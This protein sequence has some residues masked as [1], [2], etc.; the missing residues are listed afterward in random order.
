[1]RPRYGVIHAAS[2]SKRDEL[3]QALRTA[4]FTAA[5]LHLDALQL[6]QLAINLP[7][8]PLLGCW[9]LMTA[10]GAQ[11]RRFERC[12]ALRACAHGW[13]WLRATCA[14]CA[15]LERPLADVIGEAVAADIANMVEDNCQLFVNSRPQHPTDLLQVQAQ[16]L[17]GPEQDGATGRG[18]VESF[19]DHINGHQHADGASGERGDHG[20]AI[21]RIAEQCGGA[22]TCCRK[23]VSH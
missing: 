18:D 22:D 23:C 11:W 1:M 19:G 4:L 13:R 17:R 10:D 7:H 20:I 6:F 14:A 3:L 8:R 5:N 16:G 9:L 21:G 12:E 2:P 15:V